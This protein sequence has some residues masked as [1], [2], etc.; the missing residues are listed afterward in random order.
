ME[1]TR[2]LV[3]H[4]KSQNGMSLRDTIGMIWVKSKHLHWMMEWNA[5]LSPKAKKKVNF[6]Y[7]LSH[8]YDKTS[9]A[10]I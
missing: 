10:K 5:V 3:F 9:N 8:D 4:S 1:I 2:W 7:D 6:V